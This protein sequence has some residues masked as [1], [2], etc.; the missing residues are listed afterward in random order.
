MFLTDEEFLGDTWL[1]YSTNS[2]TVHL[3]PWQVQQMIIWSVFTRAGVN[4]V[5][6]LRAYKY[7]WDTL[8]PFET[9]GATS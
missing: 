2:T 5:R 9:D 7:V 6:Y 4:F 1:D 8:R 3:T